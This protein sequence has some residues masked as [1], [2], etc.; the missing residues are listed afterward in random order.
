[1]PIDVPSKAVEGKVGARIKD[2]YLFAPELLPV[3]EGAGSAPFLQLPILN[4]FPS[5]AQEVAPWY[6]G[7][8]R[9]D[10]NRFFFL[11]GP[12]ANHAVNTGG[13][14]IASTSLFTPRGFYANSLFPGFE[15]LVTFPLQAM[16]IPRVV[17]STMTVE[18]EGQG[19]LLVY[20]SYRAGAGNT[21]ND[22]SSIT[23]DVFKLFGSPGIK[24][25]Y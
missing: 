25:R 5:S 3:T 16:S 22:G 6:A 15:T 1:M 24:T 17:F 13:T 23:A 14:P 2:E 11:Q 20:S 18:L 8:S 10:F 19:Y 4:R 12:G 9:F 7:G 21:I